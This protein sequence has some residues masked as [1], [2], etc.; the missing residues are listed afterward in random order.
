M[1]LTGS[2]YFLIKS[3]FLNQRQNDVDVTDNVV[4]VTA[5][6]A[7]NA[8]IDD[9]VVAAFLLLQQANCCCIDDPEDVMHQSILLWN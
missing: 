2:C 5:I 9:P 6:I 8:V 7:V 4:D 3:P 1:Q